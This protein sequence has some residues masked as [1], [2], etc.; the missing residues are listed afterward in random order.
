M[1][2]SNRL[3]LNKNIKDVYILYPN[4]EIGKQIQTHI[5]IR[6]FISLEN[7]NA[8]N[9]QIMPEKTLIAAI[10]HNAFNG[11]IFGK[12]TTLY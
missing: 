2:N 4:V 10:M 6:L 11:M 8:S 3:S 5:T 7:T 12:W 9:I 1:T